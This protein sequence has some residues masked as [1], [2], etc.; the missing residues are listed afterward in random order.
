MQQENIRYWQLFDSNS[1]ASLED[2]VG[3]P[4]NTWTPL[5]NGYT[6]LNALEEDYWKASDGATMWVKIELPRIVDSDRIWIELAPNVGLDGELAIYEN[7]LWTWK[8]AAGR[9][10]SDNASF[11]ATFLTFVIEKPREHRLAFLKIKSSQVL[12]FSINIRDHD[13]QLSLLASRN[14]VYGLCFGLMI[15]AF[16]YNMVIG[17]SAGE[18]VY[19]YYAS[20][21][22]CMS[23]Y[24]I[25]MTGYNRLAFP[26]WGGEGSFTNL[27]AC[28]L[29]FSATVFVRELLETKTTIPKLDI[30]LRLLLAATFSTIFLLGFMSDQLAYMCVE[31]IG[32]VIPIII[33]VCAIGALKRHP[34]M[35]KLFLLAWTTHLITGTLWVWMWLGYTPPSL[36]T[37]NIFIAGSVTEQL[38]LAILLGYKYANLKQENRKLAR[39]DE[40]YLGESTQ[41]QLTGVFSRQTLYT[42]IEHTIKTS[43]NDLVWIDID[44]DNFQK[45]N[46]AHGLH[47]GDLL[48]SEFGQL[49]QT[50]VRRDNLAAKLIDKENS[51]AYRRGLAGR[52]GGGKF[53]ILL[54]NCSLPQARL[55]VERLMRD[56]EAIKIKS[57]DGKW[58]NSSI[59]VG[60]VH[61]LP[62][63]DFNS[64]WKRASKKL[65]LAKSKGSAQLSFS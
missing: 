1:S 31:T 54:S 46:E 16:V 24:M 56:F 5:P 9:H 28:L 47:A 13:S 22:L 63:E 27:T 20:Y 12:N 48:L 15:L 11:P 6:K 43:E 26:D 30:L 57:S 60:V 44:I 3:T 32:L 49:L 58:L 59:S 41:D 34:P 51:F 23:L 55:Y 33:L 37:L 45:F 14:L 53:T 61:I 19:T 18:R 29:A 10:A 17:I 25:A 39:D 21:V 52:V 36:D 4:N 65:L 35:A 64:A 8:H 38:L 42:Q 7:G 40:N 2:I 50:K 62:N